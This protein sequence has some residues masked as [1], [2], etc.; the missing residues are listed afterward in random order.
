MK[1]GITKDDLQNLDKDLI[2][3]MY[4]Q[5]QALLQS[6]S[7]RLDHLTEM[8]A[9]ANQR[10]FGRS[11][12][13]GLS[14]TP[15]DNQMYMVFNEL[16]V[17]IEEAGEAFPEEDEERI[18]VPAHTRARKKGVRK[19][20]L[21]GLERKVIT[22]DV[23][24]EEKA[25]LGEGI[26]EMPDEVY[27]KVVYVPQSFYIE[28][29]HVKVYAGIDDQFIKGERPKDAFPGSIAT[30]SIVS[31]IFNSKYVNGMPIARTEKDF[32]RLGIT[33]RRQTMCRWL[34]RTCGN[35]IIPL[36]N[37]YKDIL[38]SLHV[39][40]ADESPV[41]VN[42][43][44]IDDE[45]GEKRVEKKQC[46]MWVYK[47]GLY[48]DKKIVLYDYKAGRKGEYP[49][50]FLKDFH[51]ILVS[52][53]YQVYH[54]MDDERDDITIAGCWAHARRKFA[55]IV[56]ALGKKGAKGSVAKEALRMI[57]TFYHYEKKFKDMPPD[58]RLNGRQ[59]KIAPLVDVFFEWAKGKVNEV[60]SKSVRE[61]LG[62]SINQEKYLRVFL[63]D[64]DVPI[65]NNSAERSIRPF[66]TGRKAWMFCDTE[67]GAKTSAILYSIAETAKA[68]NLKPYEYMKYVLTQLA[69]SRIDRKTLD[70]DKIKEILPRLLPWSDDLPDECRMKEK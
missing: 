26:R 59:E 14:D 68:N 24:D 31:G 3:D 16:E 60:G 51:G 2:I 18:E 63:T 70:E 44:P 40:Q 57:D 25:A 1:K 56:K 47:S 34:D 20:D 12:E 7:E 6:T 33:I 36:Y 27:D 19:E 4:L 53:G 66:V 28:E 17:T 15:M 30:P 29:H 46:Y 21:S 8:I 65:D 35:F 22:H 23:T 64:G 38:T 9:L 67:G 41:Q 61:A 10:S 58:E 42:K 13:K 32:D 62:Y 39:A 48:E 49:E 45:D 52:D 11:S 5:Q 43:V 50:G 54:T 69:E 37:L 55:E